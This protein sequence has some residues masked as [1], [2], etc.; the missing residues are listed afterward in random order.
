[1]RGSNQRSDWS[2]PKKA[3]LRF[4]FLLLGIPAQAFFSVLV[5]GGIAATIF[6]FNASV[7]FKKKLPRNMNRAPEVIRWFLKEIENSDK[8]PPPKL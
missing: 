1:M 3:I 4:L 2:S 5:G 8:N 6:L 7:L